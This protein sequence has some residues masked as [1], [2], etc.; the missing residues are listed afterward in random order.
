M[1]RKPIKDNI[2]N[3]PINREKETSGN[4]AMKKLIKREEGISEGKKKIS[5]SNTK[6]GDNMNY[7][8]LTYGNKRIIIKEERIN[9]I[10]NMI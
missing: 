9:G 5:R 2:K 10:N 7:N 1:R 3:K 4:N 8:E 6:K